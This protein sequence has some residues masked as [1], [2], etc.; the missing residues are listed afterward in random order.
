MI[1]ELYNKITA[2]KP[3]WSTTQGERMTYYSYFAGQNIIY[4]LVSTYLVTYLMFQGIDPTKSAA[5]MAVVKVWDAVNDT[6]FGVIFDK[7]KFKSGKKYLPWIKISTILIPI[8]TIL[9][10]FIPSAFGEN[11]KLAWFAVTY[12]LWDAAYT[13]CDVPI[14]A[15]ITSMTN[16][17][18]ERNTVISYKSI[19]TYI[20]V[21]ITTVAATLLVSEQIGAGYSVVAVILCVM[22]FATMQPA[23]FKLK[24]RYHSPDEENFT[25]RAMFRYLVHNKYL[26]I[27]Y[28]GYFFYAALNIQS[29]M[30]LY[31][32]YYLFNNSLFSLVVSALGVAPSAIV[33]LLIPH[34]IRKYDKMKLYRA[35][36]ALVSILGV[37]TYFVGY[38][39]I[40][41]F[42]ILSVLRSIP[43]AVVSIAMALF[44]PDCA[45]YGKYRTGVEAKGITFAIQTFVAKLTA[46]VSGALGL[47]LLGLKSVGW[48]MVEVDS[49]KALEE[50][51]VV[52]TPHALNSLWFFYALV[53]TIGC[54]LAWIVWEF[55]RLKDKEVQIMADC[56]SG[57]ITKEEAYE[58]LGGKYGR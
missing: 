33:S 6:V 47:F 4:T 8:C 42:I 24:E 23:S 5:V 30:N 52:Q 53:P 12:M 7:V 11:A 16:N 1:R 56:N 46:A 15:I 36:M 48:Q 22:A 38:H 19:W 39:T 21:G 57:L 49:F 54:I 26:L 28:L 2:T 40:I 41:G 9:I 35:S 43:L 20:G 44:T 17:L 3:G 51:G 27:Y 29:A 32:S 14:F 50:S 31:V 55:Y 58:L 45:E 37:V 10:F 18:D 13:L 34:L 25:V